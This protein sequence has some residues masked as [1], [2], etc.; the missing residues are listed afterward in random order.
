MKKKH[1]LKA[2]YIYLFLPDSHQ[3]QNINFFDIEQIKNIKNVIKL[4]YE[5]KI[6]S[7]DDFAFY[8]F[9][10]GLLSNWNIKSLSIS[11]D[12]FIKDLKTST[13]KN[14]LLS[15]KKDIETFNANKWSQLYY[16][17]SLIALDLL[18]FWYFCPQ[19][20]TSKFYYA[21]ISQI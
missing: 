7:S 16:F 18:K 6:I 2:Y 5:K 19:E 17:Q 8:N 9:L 10:I 13:Y 20:K 11:I 4:L 15:F 3:F 14:L 12:W 1:E 21:N